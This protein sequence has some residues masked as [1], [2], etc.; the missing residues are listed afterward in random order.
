[1]NRHLRYFYIFFILTSWQ[2]IAEPKPYTVQLMTDF[3]PQLGGDPQNIAT[4]HM[5]ALEKALKGK[6]KLQFAPA[7]R[8]REWQQLHAFEDV[9]LYNKVKNPERMQNA[10]FTRYPIMAFPA[11]RLIVLNNPELPKNLSLFDA[12]NKYHL[13][14]GITSGRSYGHVIDQYIDE[15]PE[16]FLSLPGTTSAARLSKMLFEKK[17]D[18]IIEY[19]AVFI[20]RHGKDTRIKSASYLT[21]ENANDAIFGYIACS[22]SEQGQKVTELFDSALQTKK[23]QQQIINAHA[24]VIPE[25]EKE[26]ILQALI[27]QF[28]H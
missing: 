15:H 24:E 28:K 19:S 11:N 10:I 14:I 13:T 12:V 26:L 22:K 4:V 17:V 20:S 27:T 21:I 5:L 6:I 25:P 8:M 23:I 7:S 1:M 16:S 9:C 18:A 2:L 3:A